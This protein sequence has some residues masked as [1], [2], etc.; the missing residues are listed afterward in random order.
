MFKMGPERT[1]HRTAI[2]AIVQIMLQMSGVNVISNYSTTIYL[3][4][5]NF[6]PIISKI[7]A[8]SCQAVLGFGS[9]GTS[10]VVDRVG[11]RALMLTSA[12][13]M[14]IFQLCVTALVSNPENK[15]ALKAAVAFIFLYYWAYS[16]GFLGVPFLYASE[17]AP[18]KQ[19]A[20]ICGVSTAVSWL[21]N[22]LVVEVTP[23]A[24]TNIGY[25]YF[26]VY[27]VICFSYLPIIYFFFPETKGRELEEIDGIFAASKSIFDTVHVAKTMPKQHLSDF[28]QQV[29]ERKGNINQ[30]ESQSEENQN[31]E[32]TGSNE[33]RTTGSDSTSH[34]RGKAGDA[35]FE[36]VER[37]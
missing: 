7:L 19:R 8:A 11:R 9:I 35:S 33:L 30:S 22:W 37:V 36:E 28:M 10:F 1:L 4:Q 20:A 24:F 27:T 31:K 15:T 14:G 25:R 16:V 23:P 12:A 13:M 29:D 2:A 5:L 6:S 34:V 32:L 26:I 21:F 3:Q 17:I 18:A